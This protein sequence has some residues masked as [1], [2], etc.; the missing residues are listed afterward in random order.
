[1]KNGC[2]GKASMTDLMIL[3][4]DSAIAIEAKWTECESRYETI[5]EWENSGDTENHAKVLECWRSYINDYLNDKGCNSRI[6][7][8]P[9]DIPYQ[10]LH[11]VASACYTAMQ[12]KKK[13]AI[14]VYHLF[15]N[16]GEDG[17]KGT[18]SCMKK[19]YASI[20]HRKCQKGIVVNKK[21]L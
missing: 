19:F 7:E 11:R 15:Y 4:T 12:N 20:C 10:L 13:T 2:R 6:A 18:E 14:V 1:M 17:K 9:K 8:V 5:E 21:C 3:S 16:K